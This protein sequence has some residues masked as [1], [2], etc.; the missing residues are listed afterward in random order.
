[1]KTLNKQCC[2]ASAQVGVLFISVSFLVG[3][4]GCKKYP[5]FRQK[6]NTLSHIQSKDLMFIENA[7]VDSIQQETRFSDIFIPVGARILSAYISMYVYAYEYT[8]EL[9][10][11]KNRYEQEMER[12]GW[13]LMVMFNFNEVL[14]IFEKPYKKVAISIRPGK[15]LKEQAVFVMLAPSFL[16]S[17]RV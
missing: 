17:D 4:T 5:K 16:D 1:V 11:L 10:D 15:K 13:Q 14:M 3:I 7:S 6:T 12:F 2:R 8:S 9:N